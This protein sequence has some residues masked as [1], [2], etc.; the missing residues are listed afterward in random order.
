MREQMSASFNH[1]VTSIAV[2]IS[3]H[4]NNTVGVQLVRVVGFL[5]K[6]RSRIPVEN[7]E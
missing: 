1:S 5:S 4:V 7:S 6:I 3:A 2:I